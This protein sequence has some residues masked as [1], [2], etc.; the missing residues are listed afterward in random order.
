MNV[1]TFPFFQEK[2]MPLSLSLSLSTLAGLIV[3]FVD[4][5]I[6]GFWLTTWAAVILCTLPGLGVWLGNIIRKWMMPDAVYGS[7]G[8][9]VKARLFWAVMPQCIGWLIGFMAALGA[10]DLRT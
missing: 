8:A 9:V 3:A 5:R 1:F 10:L 4:T 7:A 2:T 6:S